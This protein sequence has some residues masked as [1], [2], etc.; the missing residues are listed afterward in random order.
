M[1]I[2]GQN[3][4]TII[5]FERINLIKIESSENEFDIEI[6]YANDKWDV[7]GTYESFER[8]KEIIAELINTYL[9]VV[10]VVENASCKGRKEP[11]F[12]NIPKVYYMPK[13]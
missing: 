5:N 10:R 8:A 6:N 1:L 11:K 12:Y 9:K 7:I 3:G 4:D 2:L 13:E